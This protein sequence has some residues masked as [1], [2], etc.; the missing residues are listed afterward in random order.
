MPLPLLA[1][2]MLVAIGK[3]LNLVLA[4]CLLAAFASSSASIFSALGTYC[5]LNP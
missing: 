1:L 2:L 5:R 4:S 3:N